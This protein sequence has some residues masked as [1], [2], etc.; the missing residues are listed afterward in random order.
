LSLTSYVAFLL[1]AI[2]SV[3]YLV[4]HKMLKAKKWNSIFHRLP[5]LEQMDRLIYRLVIVGLPLL[6]TGMVLGAVWAYLNIH[7][8]FWLDPKV[9]ASMIVLVAYSIYLF[10]R[11]SSRWGGNE[12]AKWNVGAFVMVLINFLISNTLSKFHQWM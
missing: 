10:N 4:A 11:S 6:L 3:F 7:A 12:S 5:S 1:S 9:I 8:N 2:L